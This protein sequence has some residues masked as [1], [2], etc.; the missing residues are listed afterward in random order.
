MD[1]PIAKLLIRQSTSPNPASPA[2]PSLN[3]GP[4]P[5]PNPAGTEE[6]SPEHRLAEQIRVQDQKRES[7]AAKLDHTTIERKITEEERLKAEEETKLE[8]AE[9]DRAKAEKEKRQFTEAPAEIKQQIPPEQ[10]G[11]AI[12][13]FS[14]LIKAGYTR[15]QAAEIVLRKLMGEGAPPT[16]QPPNTFES[17]IANAWLED[18]QAEM[19]ALREERKAP[20]PPSETP[21]KP[22]DPVA[23]LR[24]QIELQRTLGEEYMRQYGLTPEKIAEMR[25][26][27]FGQ[28]LIQNAGGNLDAQLRIIEIQEEQRKRW[29]QFY[30]ERDRYRRET[31]RQERAAGTLDAAKKEVAGGFGKLLDAAGRAMEA[32]SKRAGKQSVEETAAATGQNPKCP[33]CN[34]ELATDAPAGHL[35]CTGCG[36]SY[37]IGT[38]R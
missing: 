38:A 7:L 34:A 37:P 26:N 11:E 1:N 2:N 4:L 20:P 10:F 8:E 14:W 5:N 27:P 35:T 23:H 17:K 21:Q 3:P 28:N 12:V 32:V 33:E 6:E 16:T 9:R 19:K 18:V 22:F 15:E 24:Q 31:D 29:V 36:R 25:S 30:D 13:T